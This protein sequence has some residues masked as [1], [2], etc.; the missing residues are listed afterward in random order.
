VLT[1]KAAISA[2]DTST[3]LP[4]AYCCE[5]ATH[6]LDHCP[7]LAKWTP[8]LYYLTLDGIV[9]SKYRCISIHGP[10]GRAGAGL[11]TIPDQSQH[12]VQSINAYSSLSNNRRKK[13]PAIGYFLGAWYVPFD[14]DMPAPAKQWAEH[15]YIREFGEG[16]PFKYHPQPYATLAFVQRD[17][18][19]AEDRKVLGKRRGFVS[20]G[21]RERQ[22]NRPRFE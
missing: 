1:E 5:V 7:E 22:R 13:Q 16:S 21:V 20:E 8:D 9:V 2:V 19:A 3:D 14:P 11:E 18:L 15:G 17:R 6:P 12:L 4:C 10:D